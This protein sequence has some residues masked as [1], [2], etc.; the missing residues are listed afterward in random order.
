[1]AVHHHPVDQANIIEGRR[2]QPANQLNP[3]TDWYAAPDRWR[4]L[5]RRMKGRKVDDLYV[6]R[7]APAQSK[8]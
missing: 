8:R 2:L 7:Q 6:V 4:R 1:M 5:P 3:Q